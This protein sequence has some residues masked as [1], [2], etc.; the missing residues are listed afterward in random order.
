MIAKLK[1]HF[2]RYGCPD[3]VIS[4]NGP[5]FVSETF[6]TFAR[7]WEFQ[8]RTISPWNS[9]AN[10][11]VEAAVKVAKQLL[12]KARD[13]KTDIHLALL[14][15]RNTPTQ[16]MTTS[17]VQRFLN[18]RT[19]TLLPTRESLLR[20][21]VPSP[22]DQQQKIKEKQKA[23][24]HYYNRNARDLK[25]LTKGDV[26]RIKPS[27]PSVR[28]WKKGVVVQKIDNRSYVVETTD[29]TR[30]RR[31]RYHLRKTPASSQAPKEVEEVELG[32]EDNDPQEDKGPAEK[33]PS[34]TAETIRVEA[35]TPSSIEQQSVPAKPARPQRERRKPAYLAD[36]A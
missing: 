36:Y 9:K 33:P 26:V 11:K 2:A 14:D 21:K 25:E 6:A 32:M 1:C 22:E 4:D 20:P 30:Y 13:S 12:R 28:V 23:Q 24:A 7:D 19:K 15:Q 17:P 29:G 27:K 5:Q 31:N 10:G 16:A 18:R 8:H 3:T 35:D 34:P